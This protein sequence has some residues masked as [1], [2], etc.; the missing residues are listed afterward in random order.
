M[1][2]YTKKDRF[3]FPIDGLEWGLISSENS[4]QS[5]KPLEENEIL[6]AI[7]DSGPLN[8]P[9]KLVIFLIRRGT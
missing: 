8:L 7:E 5:E 1:P 3:K 9:V 6:K 2:L 4:I